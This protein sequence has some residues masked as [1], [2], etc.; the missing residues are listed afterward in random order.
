MPLGASVSLPPPSPAAPAQSSPAT[1]LFSTLCFCV[2]VCSTFILNKGVWAS[3][4]LHSSGVVSLLEVELSDA[5]ISFGQKS[6]FCKVLAS[7]PYIRVCV[8]T[9]THTHTLTWMCVSIRVCTCMS[10]SIYMY[11]Y[12]P[13]YTHAHT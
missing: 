1:D 7:S 9:C 10:V 5:L 3:C 4:P 13:I 2:S 8:H 11:I 12:T 6:P